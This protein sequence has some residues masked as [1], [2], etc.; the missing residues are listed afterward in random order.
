V[1]NYKGI[2]VPIRPMLPPRMIPTC[3]GRISPSHRSRGSDA[4]NRFAEFRRHMSPLR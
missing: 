4:L 1:N 3:R 2:G